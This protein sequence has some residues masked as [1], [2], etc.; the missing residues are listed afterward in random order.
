MCE[1][2]GCRGV[3]PIAEL[4]D[5][6]TALID[7]AELVR[8]D[9]AAGGPGAALTRLKGLVVNLERHVRREEEGVFRAMRVTGEFVEEVEQ[10]EDEHRDFAAVIAG[11]EVE[12]PEFSAQ[13]AR[14]LAD[15]A[16]HVDREDLGIFPVSVVTLG[17]QGWAMVD[18][19]H[20][21]HPSFLPGPAPSPH[22]T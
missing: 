16:V 12:A 14:L 17:A 6:H 13:V 18:R 9:L 8:H 22:T 15:L 19:A 20:A 21:E 3:A 11:L 2:C 5:E 7:E 1:Y 10:L 4:M